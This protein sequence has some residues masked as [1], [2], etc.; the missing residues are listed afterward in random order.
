VPLSLDA[1]SFAKSG[2]FPELR[3]GESGKAVGGIMLRPV[4]D[5]VHVID[6]CD[7]TLIF[8]S[9]AFSI[10]Q[11]VCA[12]MVM[13]GNRLTTVSNASHA[14]DQLAMYLYGLGATA[15]GPGPSIIDRLPK[16]IQ[17][18]QLIF[19]FRPNALA[20]PA[21]AG[22]GVTHSPP[23]IAYTGGGV[24]P[25]NFRVPSIPVGIPSCDGVRVTSNMTVTVSGPNSFDA[26]RICV[27]P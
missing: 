8:L 13:R 5:S 25:I 2:S 24:Y 21:V 14:G 16:P 23:F 17:Q 10:P 15:P 26:A 11:G 9:A 22:F 7:N 6:T 3:I 27:A 4:S 19:D 20:S 1:D 18:F 12:P